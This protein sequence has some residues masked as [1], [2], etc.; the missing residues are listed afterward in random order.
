[1]DRH[2]QAVQ[3][4]A[5]PQQHPASPPF[6]IRDA[7]AQELLLAARHWEQ[8]QEEALAAIMTHLAM[9]L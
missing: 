4:Q 2:A 7:Q 8:E 3:L 9:R 6:A 1:V 5:L